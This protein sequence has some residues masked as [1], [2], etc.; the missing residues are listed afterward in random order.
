MVIVSER[1]DGPVYRS[2][3]Q[4]AWHSHHFH[5]WLAQLLFFLFLLHQN[6]LYFRRFNM[7][8]YHSL[9]ATDIIVLLILHV[10][11]IVCSCLRAR[12][13]IVDLCIKR[14]VQNLYGMLY[15]GYEPRVYLLPSF[16]VYQG[17]LY[18]ISH[19]Y[20]PVLIMYARENSLFCAP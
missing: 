2:A 8:P 7:I 20:T 15:L 3:W 12:M 4:H 16:A 1:I 5:K 17:L 14:K 6:S 13:C 10:V 11:D 9:R 19:H 18:D